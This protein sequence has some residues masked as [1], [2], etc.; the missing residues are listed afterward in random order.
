MRM[1]STLIVALFLGLLAC[2]NRGSESQTKNGS[3]NRQCETDA[4]CP[5]G[6]FCL[7]RAEATVC[8]QNVAAAQVVPADAAFLKAAKGDYVVTFGLQ[9]EEGEPESL[10][11]DGNESYKVLYRSAQDKAVIDAFMKDKAPRAKIFMHGAF[12][13]GA[14]YNKPWRFVLR[15]LAGAEPTEAAMEVCD[16]SPSY[17]DSLYAKK[18]VA[19]FIPITFDGASVPHICIWS[20]SPV[21]VEKDGKTLW[22]H[23]LLK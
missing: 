11:V 16:A 21:Q 22:K 9:N 3:D 17:L 14:D 7:L 2:K 1:P 8:E 5:E 12:E 19:G 6:A 20:Y 4:D 18:S 13:G 23:A 10:K 15:P